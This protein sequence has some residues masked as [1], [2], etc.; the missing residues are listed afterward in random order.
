MKIQTRS[1]KISLILTVTFL[2]ALLCYAQKD[3]NWEEK[4]LLQKYKISNPDFLKGKEAFVKGDLQKAE[5]E[6]DKCLER[7]PQHAEAHFFLSQVFY[8]RG[9][10]EKALEEMEKAESNYSAIEKI[11]ARQDQERILTL[12]ERR[13]TLRQSL[14]ALK[15]RLSKLP[16]ESKD[17]REL[18]SRVS[19]IEKELSDIDNRLSNPLP[20]IDKTPAEYFYFHGN[21]FFKMKKLPDA[22]A[23]YLGAILTDPKHANAYNNLATLYYLDRQYEKALKYLNQAEANGA[24]VNPELKSA[25]LKALGK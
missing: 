15:E 1:F 4:E 10:L 5:K 13:D 3:Y 8:K 16:F 21:I 25:V 17:R 11:I 2:A 22:E 19:N 12:Q 7:M 14:P 23:Q 6:L 9:N 24:Q 20:V 18:E